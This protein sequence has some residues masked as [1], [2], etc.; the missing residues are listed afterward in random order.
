VG[1]VTGRVARVAITESAE[2]FHERAWP[3]LAERPEHNV[4]AT[5]LIGG[6]AGATPWC[7]P[8]AG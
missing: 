6:A 8:G 3:L 2:E 4:L 5:I 7:V 1:G